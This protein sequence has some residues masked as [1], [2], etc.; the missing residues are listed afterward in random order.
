MER[1][2]PR[3]SP[4]SASVLPLLTG[5]VLV[6]TY[7]LILL[8]GCEKGVNADQTHTLEWVS[9]LAVLSIPIEFLIS[10]R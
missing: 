5:A 4:L 1:S 9:S 8:M 3:S 10:L 2:Y 6:H 7:L